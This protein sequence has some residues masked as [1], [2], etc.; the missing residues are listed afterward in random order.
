GAK[1]NVDLFSRWGV[2]S[3]AEAESRMNI[4]YESY[5][6]AIAIEGQSALSIARTMILPAAQKTLRDVADSLSSAKTHGLA[7]EKQTERLREMSLHIEEFLSCMGELAT[8]FERAES[9][10]GPEREHAKIYRDEVVP[11]MKKLRVQADL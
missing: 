6:K 9:H 8:G 7:I 3:P 5:A 11:A 4:Q 1:K 10:V 2:L